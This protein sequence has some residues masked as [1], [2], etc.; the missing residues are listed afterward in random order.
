[1]QRLWHREKAVSSFKNF[2][3]YIGRHEGKRRRI[4]QDEKKKSSV[5]KGSGSS[6]A[7]SKAEVKVTSGA[8]NDDLGQRGEEP[9]KKEQRQLIWR[10]KGRLRV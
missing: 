6:S 3:P 1:M 7:R 10:G 9:A 5:R 8:M 4:G 2:Q